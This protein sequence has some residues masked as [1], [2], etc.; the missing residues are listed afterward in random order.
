MYRNNYFAKQIRKLV[1]SILKLTAKDIY[2]RHHFTGNSFLLNTYHHK[3]YWFFGKKRERHTMLRFSEI[4]KPG[5]VVLEIGGHI[6]YLTTYFS[7][8]TGESGRVIVF[9]PGK[10]NLEYLHKNVKNS[11]PENI[12]IEELAAG[13][14]NCT[15]TFYLDPI[16]GQ[17]NSGP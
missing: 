7:L 14:Q 11:N 1:L 13:N 10:N 6:G 2:I 17:N 3:G 16:T 15:M 9:E 5:M 8:L 12:L 4:I